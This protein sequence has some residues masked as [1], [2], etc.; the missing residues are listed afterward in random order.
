MFVASESDDD[1]HLVTEAVDTGASPSTEKT[2]ECLPNELLLNIFSRLSVQD[3]CRCAQVCQLWN[4]L[5]HQKVLWTD[6]LPIDWAQGEL[7]VLM[8]PKCSPC[9]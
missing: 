4:H 5:T 2:V 8:V 1:E 3:I 6:F 9:H 7:F